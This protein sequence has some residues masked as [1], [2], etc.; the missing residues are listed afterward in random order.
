MTSPADTDPPMRTLWV[1]DDLDAIQALVRVS[2]PELDIEVEPDPLVALTGLATTSYAA[3]LVDLEFGGSC[4]LGFGFVRRVGALVLPIGVVVLSGRDS[5]SH[6]RRALAEGAH[7]FVVNEEGRGQ[8]MMLDLHKRLALAADRAAE[9]WAAVNEPPSLTA[10][11]HRLWQAL[12]R[13]DRL[14]FEEISVSVLSRSRGSR[15]ASVAVAQLVTRL[16]RKLHAAGRGE[17]VHCDRG[18]GYRL[19][20]SQPTP[21]PQLSTFVNRGRG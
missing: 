1:A 7:D 20:R 21:H 4:E 3:A 11:E 9:R 8:Q 17:R 12:C 18:M 19:L 15:A 14:T 5:L 2:P 10:A 13:A 6:R 16:R